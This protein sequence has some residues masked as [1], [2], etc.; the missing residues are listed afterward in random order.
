MSRKRRQI[1]QNKPRN[2]EGQLAVRTEFYRDVL[3]RTVKG[4]F[5]LK[6]PDYCDRDY[7]LNTL[8]TTGYLIITNTPAGVLPLKGSVYGSNYQHVQTKARIVVPNL[9]N[10][11]KTIGKDCEL[12]YM[13]RTRYR[14]FFTFNEIID[15]FAYKLAS[16]DAGIDVNILNSKL[17]YIAEAGNKAES[18]TIK[19]LFD[20][21]IEGEPMVVYKSDVITG[22]PLTVAFNNLKQNFIVPELQDAKRTIINEFLTFIG[23]NNTNTDKKER[24]ITTEVNA[25]NEELKCN[26]DAIRE[27]L[28]MCNKKVSTMFPDFDFSLEIQFTGKEEGEQRDIMGNRTDVG[29]AK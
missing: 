26:M 14:T 27:T 19:D 11:K 10:L 22:Q 9:I 21:I 16:C 7:V 29:D 18:E 28:K 20:K 25:N 2:V 13:E 5:K 6:C 3:F 4:L 1:T 23:V 12:V 8:I 24:L 15:V 17:A